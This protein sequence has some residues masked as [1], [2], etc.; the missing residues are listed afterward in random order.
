MTTDVV[1]GRAEE[2]VPARRDQV[3]RW[4][5]TINPITRQLVAERTG[6]SSQLIPVTP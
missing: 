6:Y 4:L 5:A 1:P 3:N 2:G